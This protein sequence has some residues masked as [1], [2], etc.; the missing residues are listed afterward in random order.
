MRIEDLNID[1][2]LE[3]NLNIDKLKISQQKQIFIINKTN[4]LR[5]TPQS[6][7]HIA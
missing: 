2:L 6:T 7:P 1:Q 5:Y 3:M 4:I